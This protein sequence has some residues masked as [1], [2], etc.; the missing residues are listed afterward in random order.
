[1]GAFND[2]VRGTV[3]EPVENR[4]V[5]PVAEHIM[6]GAAYLYRIQALKMQGLDFKSDLVSY[7]I[8]NKQDSAP[9]RNE[10]LSIADL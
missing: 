5:V 4:K 2:W 1:M 6:Q 7:T 10:V 3:L 8:S 9:V